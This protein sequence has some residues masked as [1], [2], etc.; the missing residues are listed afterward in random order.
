MYRLR[1]VLHRDDIER[2]NISG[3]DQLDVE[4]QFGADQAQWANE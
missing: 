3:Y 1:D 4:R 2:E